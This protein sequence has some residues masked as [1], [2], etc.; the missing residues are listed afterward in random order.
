MAAQ[1]GG[2]AQCDGQIPSPDTSGAGED[3][4]EGLEF[5]LPRLSTGHAMA[6]S[7]LRGE[8]NLYTAQS[9]DPVSHRLAL[10]LRLRGFARCRFARC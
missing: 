4:I 2:I 1:T 3:D 6:P 8:K 5:E 7:D 10:H 9:E